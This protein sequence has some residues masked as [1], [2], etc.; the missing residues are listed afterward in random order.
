[1][2]QP[3][4]PRPDT[5]RGALLMIGTMA[6]FAAQDAISAHLARE[7]NPI[8]ITMIRYW[9]FLVFVL[10]VSARRPGGLRAAART[11][12]PLLQLARG[13][14]LALEICVAVAA[15]A[16]LG[17]VESHAIFA[18]YPLMV[19]AM[20]GPL[21]GERIGWRRWAAIGLGFLGVLIILRPGLRAIAPEALIPLMG[22][23]MF[24]SYHVMTRYANRLDG[25]GVSFFYTGI[26]G[27]A[28]MTLIG[29]FF[30]TPLEGW[31]WAWMAALCVTGMLGHYLLIA[32]LEAAEASVAQPFAFLHLVFASALGVA[33]FGEALSGFTVAGATLVVAAGLFTLWREQLSRGRA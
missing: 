17:L 31:S 10:T 2:N 28:V 18:V 3:A 9:A 21:L 24:A 25:A 30:W 26:G 16:L 14:L 15:F 27:A 33:L 7:A 6:V 8:V 19:T 1:M 5:R 20:S 13:A 32:A 11:R 12:V 23:A 29:P 4:A 22:A